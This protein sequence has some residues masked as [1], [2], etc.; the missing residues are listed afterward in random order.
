MPA[1]KTP[2]KQIHLAFFET[3]CTG[4]HMCAGQWKREGDN[5]RSK[6]R[7]DYWINIAKLADEGKITCIFF[8]DSYAGKDVLGDE[9]KSIFA[10]GTNV[11]Q[12]DPLVIISAM[13]AVTKSVTYVKPYIVSRTYSTL[14]HLTE[15]RVAWNI[16]TSYSQS[17]ADAFGEE[18]VLPHDERYAMA[19]EYMDVVYKLWESSWDDGAQVWDV[20]R[21]V[22]YDS[23]KIKKIEH[24][25]K[26]LKMHARNQVHPSPQRT[27]VLFQAGASKTGMG[28]AAKHA[29]CIFLAGM[30]PAQVAKQ[31]QD[32]RAAAAAA[33][34][35]P[36][37]LKFFTGFT[38]FIGATLEEAQA[39][40][41][42]ALANADYMGGLAQVAAYLGVDLSQY[43]LDEP[44]NLGSEAASDRTITGIMKNFSETDVEWT[45]RKVG[46]KMALGG[47]H[48]CPVGTPAMIADVMEEWSE[49]ADVDGFLIAYV[50][51]PASFEDVLVRRGLMWDDYEAPGGT[52]R[53]NL[54]GK[55]QKT[56]R[57][58]HYGSTFKCY[59]DKV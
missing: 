38:P 48:P 10:S 32:T 52:F 31:V 54:Y 42:A 28:F 27:P 3:A 46:L 9:M 23:S 40:Y 34:R 13:A 49:V 36:S 26:Y 24:T 14:D 37:A 53:E 57:S 58:D 35:D 17:S 30:F 7:L 50:T 41:D 33:G 56:L 55:G 2:K 18:N 22:A 1:A 6:D 25:G 19:H 16:V 5:S 20:E 43:P 39:K 11:A 15:G 44:L 29:E 12:L 47:F 4:N 45:P 8:A 21:K 59:V 51:N